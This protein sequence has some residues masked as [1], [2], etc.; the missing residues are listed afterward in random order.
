MEENSEE[1][2]DLKQTLISKYWRNYIGNY[3]EQFNDPIYDLYYNGEWGYKYVYVYS[4]ITFI[5]LNTID[6]NEKIEKIKYLIDHGADINGRLTSCQRGII[7]KY[8]V[9]LIEAVKSDLNNIIK[10]LL[11]QNQQID[12]EIKNRALS[13]AV[14]NKSYEIVKILVNN[15]STNE[16]VKYEVIRLDKTLKNI[17]KMYS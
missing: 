2:K 4:H 17:L 3:V 8:N 16:Y 1:P 11:S 7:N 13:I 5:M 14:L 9:P 15:G 6:I 10:L 12:Q